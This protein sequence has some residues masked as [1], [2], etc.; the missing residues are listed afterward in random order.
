MEPVPNREVYD[1]IILD[2]KV[3]CENKYLVGRLNIHEITW[4]W[5]FPLPTIPTDL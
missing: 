4:R 1:C 2:T 3:P 5:P